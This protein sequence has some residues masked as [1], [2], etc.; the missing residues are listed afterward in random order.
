VTDDDGLELRL[1]AGRPMDRGPGSAQLAETSSGPAQLDAALDA[2]G[3]HP[4][5]GKQVIP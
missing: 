5:S 3:P 2:G 4:T 1:A